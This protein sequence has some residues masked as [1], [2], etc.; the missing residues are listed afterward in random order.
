M[1]QIQELREVLPKLSPSDLKFA[2]SCWGAPK[3]GRGA[4]KL[5]LIGNT[6]KHA[7]LTHWSFGQVAARGTAGKR[8]TYK[9]LIH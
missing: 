4:N 8:L 9:A 2:A 7:E 6:G 5:V 1:L 3:P